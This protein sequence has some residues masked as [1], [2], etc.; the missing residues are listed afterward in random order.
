MSCIAALCIVLILGLEYRHA[1]RPSSFLSIYLSIGLILDAVQS[2]SMLLRTIDLHPAGF[3]T[4]AIAGVKLVLLV[5]QEIP[6]RVA[7]EYGPDEP[8]TKDEVGGFWTRTLM[9]WINGTMF[10]GFR[11]T[12]TMDDLANLGPNFSARRLMNK[13]DPIWAKADKE[14]RHALLKA[15]LLALFWPFVFAAIPRV[16]FTGFNFTGPFLIQ[17]ILS[18]LRSTSEPYFA[19]GGLIGSIAL[20]YVGVAVSI[21]YITSANMLTCPYILLMHY[22]LD[23]KSH[24]HVHDESCWHVDSWHAHRSSYQKESVAENL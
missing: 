16:L 17:R 18:N 19:K 23:H 13:F 22:N 4:A 7:P 2:R 3:A 6:K 8:I 5:M 9:L 24:S 15:T 10:F 11:N 14:S 12:L 21:R 1:L 20:V